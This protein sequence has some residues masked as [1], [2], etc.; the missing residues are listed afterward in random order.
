MRN[1]QS[2]SYISVYKTKD[3]HTPFFAKI[4]IARSKMAAEPTTK[5]ENE[6]DAF[7]STT[8]R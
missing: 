6:L 4:T 7:N 1:L 2:T 3:L 5:V 8:E